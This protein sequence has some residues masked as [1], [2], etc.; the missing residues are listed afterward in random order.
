MGE[1]TW[2]LLGLLSGIRDL[3]EFLDQSDH[4]VVNDFFKELR[5]YGFYR[6]IDRRLDIQAMYDLVGEV[7]YAKW[8]GEYG[9]EGDPYQSV[10]QFGAALDRPDGALGRNKVDYGIPPKLLQSQHYV[11]IAQAHR[12][13][14]LDPMIGRPVADH[15]AETL[16]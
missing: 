14:D 7:V 12:P 2:N 4:N 8:K 15:Q 5:H 9:F 10:L 3:A 16:L 1:T 6:I 13:V 11:E